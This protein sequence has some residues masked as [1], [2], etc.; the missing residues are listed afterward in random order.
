[1]SVAMRGGSAAASLSDIVLSGFVNLGDTSQA[2]GFS[3]TAGGQTVAFHRIPGY[4]T[5]RCLGWYGV[6]IQKSE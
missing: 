3:D 6:I 2:S 1:M 5:Y 4:E